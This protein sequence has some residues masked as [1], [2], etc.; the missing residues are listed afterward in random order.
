MDEVKPAN[1]EDDKRSIREALGSDIDSEITKILGPVPAEA[2]AALANRLVDYMT[3][4]V[5]Q[6]LRNP[7][8]A[9]QEVSWDTRDQGRVSIVPE[10]RWVNVATEIRP[11][12]P[13]VGMI[14]KDWWCQWGPDSYMGSTFDWRYLSPVWAISF[15]KNLDAVTAAGKGLRDLYS[16]ERGGKGPHEGKPCYLVGSGPSLERTAPLLSKIEDGI[17]IAVNGAAKMLPKFDYFFTVDWKGNPTWWKGNED[18]MREAVGI[19]SW[20]CVPRLWQTEFKE[21]RAFG[22]MGNCAW[23][24]WTRDIWPWMDDLDR[25]QTSMFSAFHLAALMG[26]N[27]IIFVGVDMSFTDGKMH[28]GANDKP[29]SAQEMFEVKDL[30]GVPVLTSGEFIL[31]NQHLLGASYWCSIHGVEV[32]N[33]TDAGI[34]YDVLGNVKQMPTLQAIKYANSLKDKKFMEVLHG[35]Q[36]QQPAL[37]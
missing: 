25:G 10:K 36:A 22:Y 30:R 6:M 19:L 14:V 17:V 15:A 24:L 4:S 13:P 35:I 32:V 9:S 1:E 29:W 27:P 20:S 33:A 2:R 5:H 8:R 21:K 7:E 26:C 16:V 28:A 37:V 23:D 3:L 31:Y 12:T 18:K 34:F 11:G